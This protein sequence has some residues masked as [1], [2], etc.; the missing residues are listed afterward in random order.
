MI[1]KIVECHIQPTEM[2]QHYN[3]D[4]NGVHTFLSKVGI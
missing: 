3:L 4:I 1:T 2:I